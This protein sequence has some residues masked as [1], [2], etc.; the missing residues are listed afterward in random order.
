MPLPL[1]HHLLTIGIECVVDDP[2]GC[3]ERVIVFISKMAKAFG[4]GLQARSFG[5]PI[6]RIVGIGAVDDLAEQD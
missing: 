6:Q 3:I 4:D 5:L 1:P 2:L